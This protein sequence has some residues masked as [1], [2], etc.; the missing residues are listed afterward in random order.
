MKKCTEHVKAQDSPSSSTNND[1]KEAARNLRSRSATR[2]KQKEVTMKKCT[3]QVTAQDSPCSTTSYEHKE[4][5]PNLRSRSAK[6][7]SK[8]QK[9]V[10]MVS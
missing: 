5:A 3:E 6:R 8:E 9:E 1:H 10:S 7:K 2:K 4:E